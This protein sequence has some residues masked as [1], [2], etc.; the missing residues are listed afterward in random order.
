[1][2]TKNV[3]LEPTEAM[4]AAGKNASI[5]ADVV[6]ATPSHDEWTKF[7]QR[8]N[9]V[10]HIYNAMLAAYPPSG[11]EVVYQVRYPG[12]TFFTDCEKSL[13]DQYHNDDRRVFYTSP[14]VVDEAMVERAWEAW[15]E[16]RNG[17]VITPA[18]AMRAALQAAL[19]SNR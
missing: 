19:E 17:N 6:Y 15:C 9:R 13:Y 2:T 11:G 5:E 18:V 7:G 8:I 16:T 3:P 10:I 12:K 14:R 4:L 1:M